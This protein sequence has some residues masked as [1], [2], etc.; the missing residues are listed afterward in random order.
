MRFSTVGGEKGSA[1]TERDPRG[2]AVKFY[3]EDGNWDLVG[4]NTPIFF[5]KDPKKF[6]DFIHTQK[7]DPRTNTQ[8]P[9]HDVGF[10][11]PE[12][13]KPAPGD[14]PD[15]RQGNTIT[16]IATCMDLEVILSVLSMRTMNASG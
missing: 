16:V 6:G 15:D 9:D 10:L 12:S 8:K 11:E 14:V 7:R 5:I 4:N 1:D 13:G 3:T 2:F